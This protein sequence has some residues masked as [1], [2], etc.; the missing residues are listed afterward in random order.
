MEPARFQGEENCLL[1]SED[2]WPGE[3]RIALWTRRSW[4]RGLSFFRAT[5]RATLL[6]V[7]RTPCLG[8]LVKAFWFLA[9]GIT[10]CM[11]DTC[12]A[13]TLR[14]VSLRRVHGGHL[15]RRPGSP[16]RVDAI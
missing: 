12:L 6:A 16:S 11:E 10:V 1:A 9:A 7:A 3:S 14:P 13:A 8:R 5:D 15:S 2:E 4:C